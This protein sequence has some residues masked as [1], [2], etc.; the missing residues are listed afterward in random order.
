V[1]AP[2]VRRTRRTP[3]DPRSPLARR[4]DIDLSVNGDCGD[5]PLAA[6]GNLTPERWR[7]VPAE[8][9]RMRPEV[10]CIAEVDL[11]AGEPG[12][13]EVDLAA[14]ERGAEVDLAAR[15]RDCSSLPNWPRLPQFDLF[16]R[17][18]FTNPFTDRAADLRLPNASRRLRSC[19]RLTRSAGSRLVKR[20]R[21]GW[22]ADGTIGK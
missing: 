18:A 20:P 9:R 19:H 5:A 15:E 8:R 16:R 10:S 17:V 7:A 11:V 1:W 21:S 3:T 4:P 6:A 14:G 13:G 2:P 22:G 12:A